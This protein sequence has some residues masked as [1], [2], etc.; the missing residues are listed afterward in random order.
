MWTPL[1]HIIHKTWKRLSHTGVR[2]FLLKFP[3]HSLVLVPRFLL[4]EFKR[5]KRTQIHQNMKIQHSINFNNVHY[6]SAHRYCCSY[7]RKHKETKKVDLLT[8]HTFRLAS[9]KWSWYTPNSVLHFLTYFI[10]TVKSYYYYSSDTWFESRM[11]ADSL[12]WCFRDF[13]ISFQK[14]L[15]VVQRIYFCPFP[16]HRIC[17]GDVP[18]GARR[19][20]R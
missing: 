10:K 5:G 8:E 4:G 6:K 11:G 2:K 19:C 18:V 12:R 14:C 13:L 17:D 3:A 9:C 15:L 1:V 7:A 16:P 20:M